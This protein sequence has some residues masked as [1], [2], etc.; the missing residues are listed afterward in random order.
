MPNIPV[1]IVNAPN[2]VGWQNDKLFMESHQPLEEHSNSIEAKL[3]GVVSLISTAA[4]NEP[5]FVDWQAV[6]YVS[7]LPDG[8]PHEIGMKLPKV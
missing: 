1:A 8:L 7:Q 4:N 2:K 3:P 5:V 6:S